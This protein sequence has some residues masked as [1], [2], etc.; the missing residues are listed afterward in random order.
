VELQR[1]FMKMQMERERL[2]MLESKLALLQ[3]LFTGVMKV[4][5]Q[6]VAFD[7]MGR[8]YTVGSTVYGFQIVD[9]QDDGVVVAF[10]N[11][12]FKVPI[13]SG[14]QEK[15]KTQEEFQPAPAV[16]PPPPAMGP[17]GMETPPVPIQ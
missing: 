5:N 8:K 4:G 2:R 1:E 10:G 16:E 13:S 11:Q 3:N 12:V 14:V 15:K 7:S 17:M 9:V 6:R